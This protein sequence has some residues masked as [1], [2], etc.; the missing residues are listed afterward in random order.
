MLHNP[1]NI[2]TENWEHDLYNKT[3][4][5]NV[6]TAVIGG[7]VL[8]DNPAHSSFLSSITPWWSGI[9]HTLQVSYKELTSKI[10]SATPVCSTT[11]N[12]TN[13]VL[14]AVPHIDIFFYRQTVYFLMLIFQG[15]TEYCNKSLTF[16][17]TYVTGV[18]HSCLLIIVHFARPSGSLFSFYC[19]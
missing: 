19:G 14:K 9:L 16:R 3:L 13:S 6:N 17:S 1:L 18:L 8:S 4:R 12:I 7:P 10:L 11:N 15:L 5:L 2:N